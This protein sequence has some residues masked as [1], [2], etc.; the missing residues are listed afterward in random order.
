MSGFINKKIESSILFN[1]V[2]FRFNNLN[3][4]DLILEASKSHRF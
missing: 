3:L 4:D 1:L 2:I